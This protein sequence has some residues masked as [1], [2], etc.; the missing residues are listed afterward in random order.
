MTAPG[1]VVPK[2]SHPRA[3]AAGCVLGVWVGV[4][5]VALAVTLAYPDPGLTGCTSAQA[6]PTPTTWAIQLLTVTWA[7]AILAILALSVLFVGRTRRLA[8]PSR[9]SAWWWGAALAGP[10]ALAVAVAVLV[11]VAGEM[12]NSLG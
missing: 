5:L 7:P 11:I 4:L 10:P 8:G 6:C 3:D 1:A 9:R 12:P 2:R